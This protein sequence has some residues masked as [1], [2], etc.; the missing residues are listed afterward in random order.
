MSDRISR[1][2]FAKYAGL[3]GAAGLAGC[4]GSGDADGDDGGDGGATTSGGD[5]GMSTTSGDG[6]DGMGSGERPV[7]WIGPP[8]LTADVQ[9][10]KFTEVTGIDIETTQ[11]TLTGVVQ[12]VLT[13]AKETHDAMANS[14]HVGS[15]V[16][17]ANPSTVPIPVSDLDYWQEGKMSDIVLDPSKGLPA[18]GE[19]AERLAAHIY[20]DPE[21]KEELLMPPTV[22]NLDALAVN[23]AEVSRDTNEWSALFDDQF[24]GRLARRRPGPAEGGVRLAEGRG[25]DGEL[26]VRVQV[27]ADVLGADRLADVAGA[28]DEV[29]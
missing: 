27:A 7:K 17:L 22:F 24:A 28:A 10:E 9:N 11:G 16:T 18:L 20:A 29:A 25:G 6:G 21:N 4:T 19:Q 23:P 8:S 1:R 3:A 15:A 12:Q 14:A 13:G 5:G 26:A 2:N